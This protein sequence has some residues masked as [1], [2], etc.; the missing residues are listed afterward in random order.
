M[1]TPLP[2]K[3]KGGSTT[4]PPPP[5]Q[6][7]RTLPPATYFPTRNPDS[8]TQNPDRKGGLTRPKLQMGWG[9]GTI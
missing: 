8:G 1:A 5:I 6:K 2:K 9:V 7:T 4:D 3:I